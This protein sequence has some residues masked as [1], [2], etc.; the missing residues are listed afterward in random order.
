MIDRSFWK[1]QKVFLTGHT[2]FK[3]GWLTLWLR[4]LGAEVTGYSLAPPDG[5]SLFQAAKISEKCNSQI[6]DIL[7]LERLKKAMHQA[8]PTVVIHM[9]AQALVRLSY[10]DPVLTYQTNVMGTVN[11]LE[12]VRHC[13]SIRS[14]VIVTTD[15]CYENNEWVWGY[16]ETD[17]LGGYDPYSNSKACTELVTSAY[18]SS[19]FKDRKNFGLASGRAGN[20]I[21][22]GDFAEDRLIP[23][24]IRSRMNKTDLVIRY[25]KATRPWQHV[26]VP[27][28]GYLRLAESLA[29]EPQIHSEAFN[30]GPLDSDCISVGSVLNKMQT[31]WGE[32]LPIKEEHQPQVHEAKFLKLDVSKAAAQLKWQP[33][34]RIDRALEQTTHW[35]KAFLNGQDVSAVTLRQINEFETDWAN[36]QA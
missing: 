15:K 2:G 26:M 34:W 28:S 30:F 6:H 14:C 25:P 3:G 31:A 4:S 27:L 16:R 21:G 10:R 5:P 33:V 23:D 11:F 22:G 35:Y 24:L 32:K 7:D 18:R 19:F 8:Q 13:D 36:A 17:R 12:A 9:A 1:G 20:V 29:R